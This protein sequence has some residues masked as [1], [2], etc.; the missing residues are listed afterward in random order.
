MT[1]NDNTPVVKHSPLTHLRD[2][3]SFPKKEES[4]SI[5]EYV[6]EQMER[7]DSLPFNAVD[8]LVLSQ[9]AYM[10]LGDTVPGVEY[11]R[12]PVR[13]ADLYKAEYFE[14]YLDDVRDAKNNRKLLYAL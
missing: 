11:Q 4:V 12:H 8:S 2:S 3:F 9:L 6:Q 10:H 14:N 5:V 7:F 1:T 13:I